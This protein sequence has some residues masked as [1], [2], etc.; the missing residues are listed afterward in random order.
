MPWIRAFPLEVEPLVPKRLFGILSHVSFPAN[1][2][3]TMRLHL[4]P[5]YFTTGR[6][7]K[8]RYDTGP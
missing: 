7:T 4:E 6:I 3:K 1:A 8:F 5:V 2:A